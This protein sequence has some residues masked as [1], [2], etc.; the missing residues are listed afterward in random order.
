[1]RNI[2]CPWFN[3]SFANYHRPIEKNFIPF[4]AK[5]KAYFAR[6][7]PRQRGANERIFNSL[8]PAKRGEGRGEGVD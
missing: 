6:P 2:I 3:F 5:K 4:F 1:M 8:S 7:P